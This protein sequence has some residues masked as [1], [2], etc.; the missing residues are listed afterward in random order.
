MKQKSD[1]YMVL[2]S[3]VSLIQNQFNKVIKT[4]RTDNG[5][6]YLDTQVRSFLSKK[7]IHHQ[8][9]NVYTPQQNGLA[10]RKH[11]HILGVAR[12]LMFSMNMPKY[13]WEDAVLTATYLINRMPSRVLGYVSPRQQLLNTYPHCLMAELPLK[14]FG[15]TVFVYLQSHNRGKLD[16]RSLK[17]VFIGYSGTQKGYKCSS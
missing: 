13:L 12:S 15:C 14:I 1:L 17:C 2:E 7:G 4:I 16:R 11:R 5:S 10:E 6:E 8:T 3:F 9:S